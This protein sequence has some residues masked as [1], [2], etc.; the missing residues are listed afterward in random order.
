MIIELSGCLV[1]VEELGKELSSYCKHS[2]LSSDPQVT[3]LGL[4]SWL[5]KVRAE[6][7]WNVKEGSTEGACS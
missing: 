5:F 6:S 3:C 2:V 1:F 4:E 7:T